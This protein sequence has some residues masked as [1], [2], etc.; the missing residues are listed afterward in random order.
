MRRLAIAVVSL[1]SVAGFVACGGGGTSGYGGGG[2]TKPGA[3][4]ASNATATTSVSL[5][6]MS[7]EPPCIKVAPGA[8][9]TFTNDDTTDHTVTTDSGQP[10][11]FDSGHIA[12]GSSYQHTFAST[13]ETVG[14]HCTIHT[15]MTATVIVQ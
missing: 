4:T 2:T 3:C 14:L 11:T 1:A 13:A 7:F 10:E 6:Q 8:M 5:V 9:V 12:P 15:F